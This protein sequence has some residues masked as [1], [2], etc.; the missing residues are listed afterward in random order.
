MKKKHKENLKNQLNKNYSW[1]T[2]EAKRKHTAE[3]VGMTKKGTTNRNKRENLG[4]EG[5]EQK[6]K[7]WKVLKEIING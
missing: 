3:E 4:K 7:V 5:N 2:K 1:F 6:R